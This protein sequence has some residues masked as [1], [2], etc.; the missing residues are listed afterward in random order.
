MS[1]KQMITWFKSNISSRCM[2]AFH[3]NGN[4]TFAGD[5]YRYHQI[6]LL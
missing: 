3:N 6:D 2:H 4:E 5:D 1:L